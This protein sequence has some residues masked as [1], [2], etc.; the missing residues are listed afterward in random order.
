MLT[1]LAIQHDDFTNKK[2]L[3]FIKV[4]EENTGLFKL[5]SPQAG[6]VYDY[7]GFTFV[8][9]DGYVYISFES[10]QDGFPLNKGDSVTMLFDG[11]NKINI[12][13]VKIRPGL[14]IQRLIIVL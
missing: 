10:R 12:C 11:N 8:N 3:A 4:G 7:L 2:T 5:Y 13:L 6:T 14:S 1:E 9:H